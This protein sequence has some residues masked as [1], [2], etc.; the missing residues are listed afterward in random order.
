LGNNISRRELLKGGGL[1]AVGLVAP[2]WL[3]TVAS[4]DVFRLAKGGKLASDTVLVVCQLSGGNDGLNTVV[5]YADSAYYKWRP[6]LGISESNVLKLTEQVGLHPS[7]SGVHKLYK[8]GKVA[9]IQSVG[10][11]R[12]NRSHFR[13]M[14]IWQSASPDDG[15][16]HGWIGRHF[17]HMLKEGS[18]NPVVALGLSTEKPLALT[19]D[20]ASI[21][22]F[23]SLVDLKTM[24]GD[25]D[26]ERMLREIQGADSP[27][28]SVVK[29]ANNTALDA[30]SVLNKQ[31]AT[32]NPKQDY[33]SH[34]FG[35][36][37]QQ[38]AQIIATS[39]PLEFSTSRVADLIRMRDRRH[40]MRRC[41]RDSTRASLHSS[42]R[43]KLSAKRTKSSSS[44]FQNSADVSVRTAAR[45]RITE[46]PHRCSSLARKLKA[47]CTV[48]C[49]ISPI[50]KMAI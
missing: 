34:A 33:G 41:S 35:R 49:P 24:V 18:L 10:Y 9:I 23:A 8:E 27:K 45:A 36:G 13:S 40:R 31:L 11:P 15:L 16:R 39:P 4:A 32:F 25:P 46:L 44:C 47:E 50:L 30:M 22:C 28:H 38:L 43:W 29:A 5:P 42:E 7:M 26:A 19:G 37:F 3:S 20:N 21:P 48:R 6:T 14:D 2:R 1:I 12:P 17:D